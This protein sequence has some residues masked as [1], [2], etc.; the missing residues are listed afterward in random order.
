MYLDTCPDCVVW[1]DELTDN[2]KGKTLYIL[3]ELVPSFIFI[4]KGFSQPFALQLFN[5]A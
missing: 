4:T 5:C 3:S 1:E 2:Q